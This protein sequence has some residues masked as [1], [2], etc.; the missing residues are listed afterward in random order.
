MEK[1]ILEIPFEKCAIVRPSLLFGERA[2][3]RFGEIMGKTLA[4]PL[5]FLLTGNYKK[6]RGIDA[7][8]VAKAMIHIL[9]NNFDQKIF[10]S[11]QLH[12]LGNTN[13]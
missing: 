12:E 9:N 5:G 4:R 7:R 13:I 11:D 1:K 10:L 8:K 6:Y 2:E 3:F